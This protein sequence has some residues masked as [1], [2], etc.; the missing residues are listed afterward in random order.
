MNNTIIIIYYCRKC[1]FSRLS[2]ILP[3]NLVLGTLKI[4]GIDVPI[5]IPVLSIPS[6]QYNY[7]IV[8]FGLIWYLS[9]YTGHYYNDRG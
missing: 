5:L 8:L 4:G 3:G 2:I 6:H 1:V 9:M 7:S